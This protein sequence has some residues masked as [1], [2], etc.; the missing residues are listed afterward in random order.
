MPQS[1]NPFDQFDKP[2]AAANPFDQFDKPAAAGNPFDQFDKPAANPFDQFDKPADK[3]GGGLVNDIKS[4]AASLPSWKQVG[5]EVAD[6]LEP[7]TDVPRQ[8]A[9]GYQR[10]QDYSRAHDDIPHKLLGQ[11]GAVAGAL[12]PL[13]MGPMGAAGRVFEKT[14]GG[15]GVENA[16]NYTLPR[17]GEQG[18]APKGAPATTIPAVETPHSYATA[19][20]VGDEAA[21]NP[22]KDTNFAKPAK[23]DVISGPQ[24]SH[25]PAELPELTQ[26]NWEKMNPA[27]FDPNYKPGPVEDFNLSG[28]NDKLPTQSRPAT[29]AEVNAVSNLHTDK[30]MRQVG[31]L[32]NTAKGTPHEVPFEDMRYIIGPDGKTHWGD[33]RTFDHNAMADAAGYTGG[34]KQA[35]L[36]GTLKSEE[37]A[38]ARAQFK[39]TED[40]HDW[41]KANALPGNMNKA[42]MKSLDEILPIPKELGAAATPPAD[43]KMSVADLGALN[44]TLA[45]HPG[46]LGRASNDM[47]H[48]LNDD[49]YLKD[50][51]MQAL[52]S[53]LVDERNIGAMSPEMKEVYENYYKPLMD[54]NE[55]MHGE[56]TAIGQ[57]SLGMT[58]EE[59]NTWSGYQKGG[60]SRLSVEYTKLWDAMTQKGDLLTGDQLADTLRETPSM[61]KTNYDTMVNNETGERV[62]VKKGTG[63]VNSVKDGQRWNLEGDFK[64]GKPATAADGS[65]WHLERGTGL[66][67]EEQLGKKPGEMYDH[68]IARQIGY[69]NATLKWKLASARLVESLKNDPKVGLQ[70]Y[71][72]DR[73]PSQWKALQ[74]REIRYP[75]LNHY[76]APKWVAEIF[77]DYSPSRFN[78]S[79]WYRNITKISRRITQSVFWQPFGHIINTAQLAL[80]N[81]GWHS[82]NPT[83]WPESVADLGRA[84]KD[85]AAGGARWHE[86]EKVPG[87]ALESMRGKN[88]VLTRQY[89]QAVGEHMKA[90]PAGTGLAAWAKQLGVQPMKLYDAWYNKS[91][92]MLWNGSD[93]MTMWRLERNLKD[94]NSRAGRAPMDRAGMAESVKMTH[95]DVPDYY[96]P[97]RL[98]HSMPGG[99]AASQ[100]LRFTPLNVFGRYHYN[101]ANGL[102]QIAKDMA[103]PNATTADRLMAGGKVINLGL[104][105]IAQH[106]A[107]N[108]YQT[109]TGDKDHEFSAH[110][111]LSILNTAKNIKEGKAWTG[112]DVLRTVGISEAPFGQALTELG[113]VLGS[114]HGSDVFGR[115]I[116]N[117]G[118]STGRHAL[119]IADW[120]ANKIPPWQMFAN[121]IPK[122]SN[123]ANAALDIVPGM[124][125]TK[126]DQKRANQMSGGVPPT[127]RIESWATGSPFGKKR[128]LT[129][130]RKLRPE[131]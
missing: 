125:R 119:Q 35:V 113:S 34:D 26:S 17:T 78:D 20:S 90:D 129:K 66:E 128:P 38:A 64:Y 109:M 98:W 6:T 4:A 3:S 82:L 86:W 104:M 12:T 18:A 122:S 27:A 92:D 19:E 97:A 116:L 79:D 85:T 112:T 94:V 99:R 43:L 62:V 37:F 25:A 81:T 45:D 65:A 49:P 50:P 9:E 40:F 5:S 114:Q 115:P 32:I 21:F 29:P 15:L 44:R 36:G 41:L 23:P 33:S 2:K 127:G 52:M 71:P 77:D 58:P 56:L 87:A 103:G 42:P 118:D 61:E 28:I 100:I 22:P 126:M 11:A 91:S 8:M 70:H 10:G 16:R 124:T 60:L 88:R 96:M 89:M 57:R 46:A 67:I 80:Q 73:M 68:N 120:A 106:M 7:L 83:R 1:S 14:G 110:G 47:L 130:H 30:T 69:T 131:E 72:G 105:M 102:L 48:F 107:N 95:K 13:V 75:G 74:K 76:A 54:A 53:K 84:W 31:N 117:P 108:M 51:K 59:A 24:G 101:V 55:A 111:S 39:T 121:E 93:V 63:Y 123:W